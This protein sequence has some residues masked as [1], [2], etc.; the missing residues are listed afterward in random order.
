MDQAEEWVSLREFARRIGV[1][2]NAVQKAIESGRIE[3]RADKKIHW[4]SQSRAFRD[5]RD[6]S[7][8]RDRIEDEVLGEDPDG[9]PTAEEV[10]ELK[11]A[12]IRKEVAEADLKEIQRDEKR[13]ELVRASHVISAVAR[14]LIDIKQG[15]MTIPDRSANEIAAEIARE[16][17]LNPETIHRILKREMRTVLQRIA[18]AE[19]GQFIS[20]S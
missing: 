16:G 5:Y 3:R 15:V 12:R 20:G 19:R 8:A 13:G 18:D 1:A 7:K 17:A 11:R 9:E 2:P 6:A 10:G 4:P 14:M